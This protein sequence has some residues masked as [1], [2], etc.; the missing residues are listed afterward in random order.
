MLTLAVTYAGVLGG[1]ERELIDLPPG[2]PGRVV[3]ACP[4]GPLANGAREAGIDVRPIA[5]RPLELHGSSGAAAANLA[6]HAREVRSLVRELGPD[7][8]VAWGMRSAIAAAAVVRAVPRRP[9]LLF[10]HLD[11]LPGGAVGRAVRMAARSAD[12]V[13]VCSQAVGRDLDPAGELKDR[14][15][16][17]YPGIDLTRLAPG[18]EPGR[19]RE[20]LLLGAIEPWKRPD[21]ALEALALAR[22]ELPD[23]RLTVAGAPIGEA[24]HRLL[25]ELRRRADRP[26]LAGHVTFAGS[27]DDPA[28]ALRR[29]WCLLHCSE[30]EPF[31]RVMAEALAVG[32]PVVAPDSAG[33]AEIVDPSCGVLYRPGDAADAAA[34]LVEVL[35]DPG[36]ARA[37]GA[38]GPARAALFDLERTRARFGVDARAAAERRLGAPRSEATPARHSAIV[39]TW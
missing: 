17:V 9:G 27:L 24:G 19:E 13:S 23:V 14:L 4:E 35:G 16:V 3:V 29:A 20:V 39:V 1:L 6:G 28:G 18:G 15:S 33:P 5:S 34:A 10:R 32:R 38:A 30:R 7:L 26:D 21:L 8:V 22:S 37:L 25:A 2:L 12:R 11:F 36:R 31:G